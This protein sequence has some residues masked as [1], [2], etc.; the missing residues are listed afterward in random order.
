VIAKDH[1]IRFRGF[2]FVLATTMELQRVILPNVLDNCVYT[3]TENPL[4][5]ARFGLCQFS[6][7]TDGSRDRIFQAQ[8]MPQP[9][10]NWIGETYS[11]GERM[12]VWEFSSDKPP[13]LVVSQPLA[14]AL[15]KAGGFPT[16]Q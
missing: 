15:A 13:R 6:I 8:L 9:P 3:T 7:R 5:N 14:L 12:E 2:A 10:D 1:E 11:Y 16:R 4:V